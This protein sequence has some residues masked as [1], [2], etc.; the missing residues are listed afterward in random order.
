MLV[1][2]ILGRQ[3]IN[4]YLCA[5]IDPTEYLKLRQK[6]VGIVEVLSALIHFAVKCKIWHFK[7]IKNQNCAKGLKNKKHLFNLDNNSYADFSINL[8]VI[9]VCLLYEMLNLKVSSFN[10]SEMNQYPNYLYV[11]L[12]Q[13]IGPNFLCW[14]VAVMF[15]YRYQLLREAVLK[16][17]HQ[18]LFSF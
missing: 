10:V 3:P 9:L 18:Y 5:D 6:M 1:K 8:C 7:K 2:L 15:Y 13:I 12:F 17:I 16:K 14:T 11:Y 4:Y